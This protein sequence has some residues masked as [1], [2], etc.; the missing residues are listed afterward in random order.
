MEEY[1]NIKIT[2]QATPKGEG[3][4]VHWTLEYEKLHENIIEPYTL[5]QHALVLSKDLDAHLV[6]A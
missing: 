6:Q 2:V 5:L 3:S 1:K 4:L